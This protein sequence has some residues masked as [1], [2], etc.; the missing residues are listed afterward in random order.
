MLVGTN[1]LKHMPF[2]PTPAP[3]PCSFPTA[4][5]FS[6]Q[7]A[8]ENLSINTN[9]LC[10]IEAESWVNGT[11]GILVESRAPALPG[12]EQDS[13]LLLGAV[14][15]GAAGESLATLLEGGGGGGGALYRLPWEKL[16]VRECGC[17][18]AGRGGRGNRSLLRVIG[19]VTGPRKTDAAASHDAGPVIS[20]GAARE[21]VRASPTRRVR[22]PRAS[23]EGLEDCGG[24]A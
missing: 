22:R 17:R 7:D 23:W 19:L 12:L 10:Q 1:G 18:G 20:A 9:L 24:T 4:S 6:S 11:R 21:D 15:D 8:D 3:C 2:F 13:S 14:D 5:C 16:Q